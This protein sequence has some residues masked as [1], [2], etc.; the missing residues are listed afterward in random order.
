MVRK[1]VKHK[2]CGFSQTLISN[3]RCYATVNFFL[4]LLCVQYKW[5]LRYSMCTKFFAP[6]SASAERN[7]CVL[8]SGYANQLDYIHICSSDHRLLTKPFD[9]NRSYSHYHLLIA[10]ACLFDDFLW[11]VTK[12]LDTLKIEKGFLIVPLLAGCIVYLT[13]HLTFH[14]KIS[15]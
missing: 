14:G 3:P 2:N 5:P 8:N 9:K 12:T 10:R 11:N 4:R 15:F 6:N 7:I 13:F 1:A